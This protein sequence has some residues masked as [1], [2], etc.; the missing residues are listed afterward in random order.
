MKYNTIFWDWNGTII[1]DIDI[2]IESINSLL[3]SRKMKHFEKTED[4]HSVFCFPII[5][6]YKK[7]GFDYNIEPYETLADEYMSIY[8]DKAKKALV[9]DDIYNALKV[10]HGKGIRQIILSASEK[11][12]LSQWL[13]DVNIFN[14]FDDIIGLNNI[15][16]K[17]KV[18][19]ALDWLEK[20]P[21]DLSKAVMIGDTTHDAKVAKAMGCDCI[22]IARGHNSID[23]LS[24]ENCTVFYNA[25][26][27]ID[28]IVNENL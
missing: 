20:N 9:F 4:Y 27:L 2:S 17:G 15:Y 28:Y 16:A 23:D 14:Y 21:V 18:D 8:N 1:D 5:E 6:Y 10:F 12:G 26:R 3:R 11:S 13:K 25:M 22:L 19:I 24:A 7:V